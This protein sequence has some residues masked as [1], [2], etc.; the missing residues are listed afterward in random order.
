MAISHL[1]ILSRHL[2]GG[3]ISGSA[4]AAPIAL[5][6]SKDAREYRQSPELPPIGPSGSKL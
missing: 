5:L 2:V 4:D 3:P 6:T 1:S